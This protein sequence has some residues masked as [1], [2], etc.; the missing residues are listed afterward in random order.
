ML[1]LSSGI[2]FVYNVIIGVRIPTTD[3]WFIS[4]WLLIELGGVNPVCSEDITLSFLCF[5]VFV[6]AHAHLFLDMWDVKTNE[7][8]K[9]RHALGQ[10]EQLSLVQRWSTHWPAHHR[11]QQTHTHTH[12]QTDSHTHTAHVTRHGV[13]DADLYSLLTTVSCSCLKG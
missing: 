9:T 3:D 1:T 11:T 5:C 6:C 10:A 7:Q 4:R 2:I 8:E 12:A 13:T